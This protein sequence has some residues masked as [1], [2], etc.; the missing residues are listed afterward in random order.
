MQRSK[1]TNLWV[2]PRHKAE[3]IAGD[4]PRHNRQPFGGIGQ[5]FQYDPPRLFHQSIDS[6]IDTPHS[7]TKKFF[8]RK[9]GLCQ[10]LPCQSV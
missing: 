1:G 3:Q 8:G 10:N 2:E 9:I 4:L 5:L 7:N 6:L